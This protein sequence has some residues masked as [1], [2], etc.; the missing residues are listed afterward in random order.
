V[1]GPTRMAYGRSI[2]TVR[3]MAQLLSDLLE[4]VYSSES[5]ELP[6]WQQPS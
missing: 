1:L 5:S 6:Y 4:T 3:Y 2:S